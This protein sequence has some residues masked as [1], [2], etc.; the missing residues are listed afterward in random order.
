MQQCRK[1]PEQEKVRECNLVN[2]LVF[3][4]LHGDE[5]P[6]MQCNDVNERCWDEPRQP[7]KQVPKE[8]VGMHLL[9]YSRIFPRKRL[10]CTSSS[11]P[12]YSQGK[13]WDAPPQVYQDIPKEKVGIHLLKYTRIFPRKSWD[14]PPQVY[15]NI[16]KEKVGMHLRKYTRIFPRMCARIFPRTCARIF[17]RMCARIFPRM[18][19]R[20]FQRKI[21]GQE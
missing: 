9:K 6:S 19:A 5:V 8:M 18:C 15:Q 2:N 7:C 21:L 12:E 16:P 14:A 1:V 13:G 3:N 10:G 4:C 20:M 17:P 11:I